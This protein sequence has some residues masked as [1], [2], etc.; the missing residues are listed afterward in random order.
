[1]TPASACAIGMIPASLLDRILKIGNA[2]GAGAKRCA[3]CAK[4]YLYS[5][6]LA[7]QTDFLE[8]GTCLE[9]QDRFVAAMQLGEGE[10][11]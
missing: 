3:L 6:T 7:A 11:N 8:L 9:F 2:A 1:M 5:Q 10:G 4:E